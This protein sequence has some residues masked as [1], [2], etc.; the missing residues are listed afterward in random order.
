MTM[1]ASFTI[2][3]FYGTPQSL[4]EK[5]DIQ[6]DATGIK[7]EERPN[8]NAVSLPPIQ[9]NFWEISLHI[10]NEYS[11]EEYVVNFLSKVAEPISRSDIRKLKKKISV[12]GYIEADAPK[13]GGFFSYG[14]LKRLADLQIDLEIDLY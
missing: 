2:Y 1:N 3:G 11:F 13:P 5:L 8:K 9:E 4:T 14:L 7:G 12:Y 10:D 6:P